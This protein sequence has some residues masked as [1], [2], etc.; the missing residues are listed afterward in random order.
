MA[1]SFLRRHIFL[2]Q[3]HGSWVFL[4]SPLLIG[5][6]AGGRFTSASLSL[7]IAATAAFLVRQ[8]ITIAVKA[9]T[10]RR[11]RTELPAAGFWTA[12]YGL[13][14]LLALTGLFQAG[15]GYVL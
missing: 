7:A 15:Y 11:A 8:P 3:D 10:G 6:F 5:L 4:F 1:H 14:L 12:I 9:W 2:P 13:I